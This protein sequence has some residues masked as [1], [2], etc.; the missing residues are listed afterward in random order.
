[1]LRA[2]PTTTGKARL[3]EWNLAVSGMGFLGPKEGV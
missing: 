3:G 1:M 2:S